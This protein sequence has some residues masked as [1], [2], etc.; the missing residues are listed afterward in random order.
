[1]KHQCRGLKQQTN[2]IRTT[3]YKRYFIPFALESR[4]KSLRQASESAIQEM[5]ANILYLAFGFLEWSENI[6]GD[7]RIAPLFMLPVRLQK[8]RLNPNTKIYQYTISY[9]GEDIIPKSFVE[10]K[11]YVMILAWLYWI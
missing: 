8:G 2:D 1:M 7:L 4:L 6:N 5:G 9:S 11:N 3:L 10:G